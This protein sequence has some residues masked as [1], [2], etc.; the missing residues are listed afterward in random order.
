[1][2]F[3]TTLCLRCFIS[4]GIGVIDGYSHLTLGPSVSFLAVDA[5][6]SISVI[7]SWLGDTFLCKEVIPIDQWTGTWLA[8]VCSAASW[9]AIETWQ[10]LVTSCSWSAVFAILWIW[11]LCNMSICI[12]FLFFASLT[13]FFPYSLLPHFIL[14]SIF[15]SHPPSVPCWVSSS[16]LPLI[17]HS[18]PPF[19]TVNFPPFYPLRVTTLL[20]LGL[21]FLLILTNIFQL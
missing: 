5:F 17:L 7:S 11:W 2:Q 8:V 4:Q 9:L 13:S 20:F 21:S 10:T 12:S 1:M 15:P 18:L 6:I 3:N 19:L 16:I 14:P